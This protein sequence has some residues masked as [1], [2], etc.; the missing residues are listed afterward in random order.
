[1]SA[2]DSLTVE[3]FAELVSYAEDAESSD[4]A[5]GRLTD[6]TEWSIVLPIPRS[7][8][9]HFTAGNTYSALFS[10]NNQTSIPLYL[11]KIVDDG[12]EDV[13]LLV[14][15]C[16]RHPENFEFNRC[17]SVSLT[18]STVSGIYVP[19]SVVVKNDGTKGVYILRGSVVHFRYIE[20][21]HEGSDYY[22]VAFNSAHTDD[23]TY[24][25]ANDMIILNGKNL[26]DGRVLD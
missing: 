10:E 21:L 5:Y 23:R 16:D 4:G 2:L 19:K 12:L 9:K 20:V 13:V 24:L 26:F 3:S 14:F 1:M 15:S 8:K 17:Q 11:E 7:D 22:L 6:S 18:L 25:R